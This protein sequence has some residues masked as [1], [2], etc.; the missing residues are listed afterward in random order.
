MKTRRRSRP[1]I[2]LG[3]LACAGGIFAFERPFREY[4]GM[5]YSD[6][7]LPADYQER[8]EF[9]FA[10]L[11]H[12]DAQNTGG[13]GRGRR[14]GGDWTQGFTWWTND[15]PRADRHL[16]IALRRLT[17]VHV[18]S[19][20][21][22]VNLDDG[23]DAFD[24]PFLYANVNS[25]SLS[26]PQIVKLREYLLRGGFL[27]CD[28]VWGE[29]AWNSFMA[30][31]SR[32]FPD[33][34]PVEIE[35]KDPVF[36]SVYNLDERHQIPGEWSLR[37]GVPYLNG[38]SVPHWRGIYDDKQRLMV[39]MWV[40]SDTADSWEWADSPHYPERYSALGIRIAVNHMIYAMSH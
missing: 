26:E 29:D 5:E 25:F 14:R 28:D 9:V 33:R 19:V 36:H 13:F 30:T 15:Y 11:M 16:T 32:V 1:F 40:N 12:P 34:P 27:V 20:E 18:R 8:T 7:A 23:D 24:W 31:M 17:R 2:C 35:D 10:R 22:P 3:L 4:R 38:G 6:F 21:Q 39:A 37:S